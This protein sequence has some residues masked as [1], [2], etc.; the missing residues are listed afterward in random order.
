[1]KKCVICDCTLDES[2]KSNEHIIHNAIGGTLKDDGIYCKTCNGKF[3]SMNDKKFVSIFAPIV[4]NIN[5]HKSRNTKGTSYTG[6]TFDLAGNIY[7]ATFRDKKVVKMEDSNSKYKKY[8]DGKYFTLHFNFNL[9]NTAFKQGLSKIAFNY[10]VHKGINPRFLDGVFDYSNRIFKEKP[11]VTPFV[12]LSI[13][14]CIMEFCPNDKI[15]HSIR[16]FNIKN[17]LYAYIDL[18]NTF[19]YYIILSTCYSSEDIDDAFTNIVEANNHLE[20]GLLDSLTPWDYKDMD[21][22]ACQY[23]IDINEE[24]DKLKR[25]HNYDNID[26][27]ERWEQLRKH[28]GKIAYEKIRTDSYIKNYSSIIQNHYY[29]ISWVELLYYFSNSCTLFSKFNQSFDYYTIY[30]NNCVDILKYKKYYVN[31]EA[32]PTLITKILEQNPAFPQSYC[33]AKFDLLPIRKY[34]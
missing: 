4:D 20:D 18:F 12:P 6:V 21:I 23:R 34:K 3:G 25:Y 26:R 5:M 1:M 22:I 15:H 29:S 27:N 13:F 16:L 7:T 28:I 11:I 9:D 17:I 32:Y 8:E 10:A 24:I 19:Q 14:D 2:N 30:D 31:G 33:S